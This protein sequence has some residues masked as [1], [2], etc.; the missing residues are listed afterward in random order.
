M[1]GRDVAV[2]VLWRKDAMLQQ[3]TD[4]CVGRNL[5]APVS[6]QETELLPWI[7]MAFAPC[8][9]VMTLEPLIL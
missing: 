7:L 4:L 9:S 3:L 6:R 8:F 5:E 2:Q 1:I